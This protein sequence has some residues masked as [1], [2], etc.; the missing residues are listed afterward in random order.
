MSLFSLV[1]VIADIAYLSLFGLHLHM[2]FFGTK[3]SA[4]FKTF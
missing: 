4:A 2:F 3:I 1:F